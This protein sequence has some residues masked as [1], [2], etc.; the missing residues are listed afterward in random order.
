MD[1]RIR[2]SFDRTSTGNHSASTALEI[3]SSLD[4]TVGSDGLDVGHYARL[5]G[6]IDDA[7]TKA[8]QMADWAMWEA[9]R[10]T[11]EEKSFGSVAAGPASP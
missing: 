2:I 9:R 7:K 10:R 4:S 11:L 5:S 1:V 3:L 6:L 8:S